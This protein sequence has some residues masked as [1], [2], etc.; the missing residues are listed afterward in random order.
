MNDYMGN[1]ISLTLIHSH[2]KDRIRES[3]IRS[4]VKVENNDSR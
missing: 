3:R 1:N 4:R 2:I